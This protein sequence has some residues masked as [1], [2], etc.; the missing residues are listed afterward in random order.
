MATMFTY[1]ATVLSVCLLS[2]CSLLVHCQ[3][4]S[5]C[6]ANYPNPGEL[7]IDGNVEVVDNLLSLVDG[8]NATREIMVGVKRWLKVDFTL[9]FCSQTFICHKCQVNQ[10]T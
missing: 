2:Q 6:D 1:V 9:Y 8:L 3:S 5:G 10:T 4:G 7:L